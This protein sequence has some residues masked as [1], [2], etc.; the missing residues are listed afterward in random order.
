MKMLKRQEFD[1]LHASA[2]KG[3]KVLYLWDRAC[4]DYGFWSKAKSQKGVYFATLEKSNSVTKFVREF[5]LI[6]H[7][8]RRNERLI[9]DRIVE[10]SVGYEIRQIIYVDPS[11]STEYRYLTNQKTLPVGHCSAL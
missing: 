7:S 4:I 8:D 10:T 3:H 1:T 9:S 6:D 11:S 5:S 2:P